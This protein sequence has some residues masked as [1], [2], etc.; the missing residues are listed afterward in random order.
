[1]FENEI[2][3]R[4]HERST[5]GATSTGSS[6]INLE[7]NV[8]GSHRRGSANDGDGNDQE[9]PREEDFQFGLDGE[10]FVPEALPN[11][12][13]G[14]D[15]AAAARQENEPEITHAAHA[16]RTAALRAE[17]AQRAR[18]QAEA[19]PTLGGD[20]SGPAGSGGSMVGWTADG[21]AGLG[22]RG[23]G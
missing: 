6:K 23:K 2:A 15:A 13:G 21:R 1:M 19:F 20:T 14:G 5:H 3:L 12:D 7:F 18:E 9:A 8:R 22:R 10:A 16:E 11:Q 17:A 4:A